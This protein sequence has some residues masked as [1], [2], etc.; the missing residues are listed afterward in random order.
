MCGARPFASD[1]KVFHLRAARSEK[2]CSVRETARDFSSRYSRR[3]P[4]LDLGQLALDY[5]GARFEL[6]KL[7]GDL[8]I[9]IVDP[10]WGRRCMRASAS[11]SYEDRVDLVQIRVVMLLL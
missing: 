4:G 3:V 1:R 2:S 6:G 7:I 11:I 9:L 8:V 10:S 5:G